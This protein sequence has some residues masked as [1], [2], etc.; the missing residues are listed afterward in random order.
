MFV[1]PPYESCLYQSSKYRKY[2]N[3]FR[4]VIYADAKSICTDVLRRA[5]QNFPVFINHFIE[6]GGGH[7]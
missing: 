6:V 5:L 3:S 2:S 7:I 1:E 4:N